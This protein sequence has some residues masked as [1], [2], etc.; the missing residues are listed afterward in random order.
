MVIPPIP[1]QGKVHPLRIRPLNSIK[2]NFNGASLPVDWMDSVAL[3]WSSYGSKHPS[4][5]YGAP[6]SVQRLEY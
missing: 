3:H 4:E 6:W 2:K 5:K 1:H